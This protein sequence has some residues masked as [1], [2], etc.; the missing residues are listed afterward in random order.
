MEKDLLTKRFLSDNERFADLLNGIIFH[1]KSIIRSENLQELDSQTG[2]WQLTDFIRS[3]TRRGMKTRDLVRKTAFGTNFVVYG[4]ENQETIDYSM[5]LRSLSY[6]VGEYERQAA[7]IRRQIRRSDRKLTQGEFLYGFTKE[8]RLYPVITIVLYYGE[9]W[10]GPRDLFGMIDFSDIPNELKDKIHNYG[11]NLVEIRKLQNTEVFRTDIGPVFDF[12]RFSKD[13]YRLKNLIE[14][15]P[16]YQHMEEEAFD[17]A[18]AYTD[19]MEIKREEYHDQNGGKR[20]MCEAIKE[21]MADS[22]AEGREEGREEGIRALSEMCREFGMTEEETMA[23]IMERFSIS[24][25][26]ARAFIK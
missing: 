1:G 23:R 8:S 5:P 15:N 22:R 25:E 16:Y 18:I 2:I 10:D 4:V 20:N 17:M 24:E 7:F 12:I 3:R 13:K 26:K 21:L 11:M 9:H 19:A 14:T 6:D